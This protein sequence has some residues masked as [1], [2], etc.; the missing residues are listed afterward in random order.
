[1]IRPMTASTTIRAL[2]AHNDWARD[3]LMAC[4]G[5][6]ADDVLDRPFEMGHGSLRATL[7]H[8]L[9][10]E[11]SK[12]EEYG[13]VAQ[14]YRRYCD[15]VESPSWREIVRLG[16]RCLPFPRRQDAAGEPWIRLA[17]A[18]HR[19]GEWFHGSRL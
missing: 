17:A 11:T 13:H 12:L 15:C 18:I 3:A 1:M 14:L 16:R 2:F 7:E 10:A 9:R 5:P 6:L 8:M 4:V 19:A